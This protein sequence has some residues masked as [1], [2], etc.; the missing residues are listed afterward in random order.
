MYYGTMTFFSKTAETVRDALL[1]IGT[2]SKVFILEVSGIR[3]EVVS[4]TPQLGLK[5]FMR[6]ITGLSE[7]KTRTLQAI[8]DPDKRL[9]VGDNRPPRINDV[10]AFTKPY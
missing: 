10:I 4:L 8:N 1:G 6:E 5:C 2:T 9:N 3:F 7:S